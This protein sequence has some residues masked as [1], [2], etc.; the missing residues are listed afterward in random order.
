MKDAIFSTSLQTQV[1]ARQKAQGYRH[2]DS[3]LLAQQ[4]SAPWELSVAWGEAAEL[5]CA[6][7]SSC[8]PSDLLLVSS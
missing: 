5:P 6:E 2:Q 7:E 8:L 4:E 3:L 1:S